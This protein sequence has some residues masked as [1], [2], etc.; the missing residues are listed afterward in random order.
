MSPAP[1]SMVDTQPS[2]GVSRAPR[3]VIFQ[4]PQL[5]YTLQQIQIEGLP[6]NGTSALA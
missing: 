3:S 6:T 4:G 2:W 1:L 5:L